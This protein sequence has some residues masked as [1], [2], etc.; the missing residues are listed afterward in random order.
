MEAMPAVFEVPSKQ[1]EDKRLISMYPGVSICCL[2][3]IAP[4]FKPLWMKILD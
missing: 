2:M 4:Y 3:V 1:Q